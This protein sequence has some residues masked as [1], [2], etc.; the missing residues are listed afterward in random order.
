MSGNT[1]KLIAFNYF[2]GKFSY[3]DEI[4]PYFPLNFDHLIELFGGS[5]AVSLNY[6]GKCIITANE[7]NSDI[8]NFFLVLRNH[9]EELI[10][11]LELTPVSNLEYLNSWE[12]HPTDNI[13]NARRFYVRARQSFFGLGAQRKNKGWH[14]AKMNKT[15]FRGETVSRWNNSFEK[16]REVAKVISTNFQISNYSYETCIDKTDFNNAFFYVDPPYPLESRASSK[17]YKY[18][19][20]DKDHRELAEKLHNIKGKAMISGYNCDLMNEL[21]SGWEKVV[22]NTKRNNYRKTPVQECIWFNYSLSETKISQLIFD[23]STNN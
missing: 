4:Y 5:L 9:T 15:C 21:Y 23:Y 18:E 20:S 7:I 14:M 1:K 13:E 6:S 3:V 8:T 16:L 22:L 19:F 17:D 10:E 2:G 12:Y 11:K